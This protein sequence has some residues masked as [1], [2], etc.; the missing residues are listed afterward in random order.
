MSFNIRREILF[1]NKRRKEK[2]EK[3][4]VWEFDEKLMNAN[5]RE[6][7]KMSENNEDWMKKGLGKWITLSWLSHNEIKSLKLNVDVAL[8]VLIQIKIVVTQEDLRN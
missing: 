4:R 3:W 7:V 6:N 5:M 2:R 1:D 8:L